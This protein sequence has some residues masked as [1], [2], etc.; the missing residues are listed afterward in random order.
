MCTTRTE[1][2]R[3]NRPGE[4]EEISPQEKSGRVT[5]LWLFFH[6]TQKRGDHNQWH[7]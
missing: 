4:Q 1:V 5:T 2:Q 3:F 7:L 6:C